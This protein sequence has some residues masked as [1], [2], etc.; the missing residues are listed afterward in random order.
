MAQ[1]LLVTQQKPFAKLGD[2]L[3]T[4]NVLESSLRCFCVFRGPCIHE[5]PWAEGVSWMRL[6]DC[7]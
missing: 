6:A 1:Q 7:L 4:G 3:K 2:Q 5:T